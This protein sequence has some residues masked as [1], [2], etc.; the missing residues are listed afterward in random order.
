MNNSSATW[1]R[2]N[3]QK[4]PCRSL[5]PLRLILLA[6]L[7]SRHLPLAPREKKKL[8][9]V[10][11]NFKRSLRISTSCVQRSLTVYL[12]DS[13]KLHKQDLFVK[14]QCKAPASLFRTLK[15]C[16]RRRKQRK[17]ERMRRQKTQLQQLN[18][19]QCLLTLSV[20]WVGKLSQSSKTSAES[21][22]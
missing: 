7:L 2:A 18:N 3:Y 9:S 14:S 10:R 1:K 12:M 6:V 15:S 21:L 19:S 16:K 8:Y 13:T 11:L 22:S 5:R 17:K 4:L 20:P